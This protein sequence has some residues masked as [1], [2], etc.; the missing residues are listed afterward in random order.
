MDTKKKRNAQPS[1]KNPMAMADE[2]WE[3]FLDELYEGCDFKI[4]KDEV[5]QGENRLW[6]TKPDGKDSLI[7]TCSGGYTEATRILLNMGLTPD[8]IEQ[9]I[10][11]FVDH[12]AHLR[13]R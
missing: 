13:L 6:V 4:T 3:D 11:Y 5:P 2:K 7:W 9:S 1:T 12:G 10:T 8:A